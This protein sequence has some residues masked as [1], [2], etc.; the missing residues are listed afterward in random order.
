MSYVCCTKSKGEE[1][2]GELSVRTGEY[3]SSPS[4]LLKCD[5]AATAAGDL[6]DRIIVKTTKKT[7]QT[8][9]IGDVVLILNFFR[10][11]L[12]AAGSV[13]LQTLS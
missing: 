7:Q 11:L 10:I 1:R 2:A 8:T 4:P 5:A 9:A 3:L 12:R 13:T 6:P